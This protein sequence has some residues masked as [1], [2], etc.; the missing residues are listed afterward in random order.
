MIPQQDNVIV[1]SFLLLIDHE[2]QKQGSAYTNASGYFYPDTNELQGYYTYTCSY[3]QLCNDTSISGANVMSG[4]Y[5]NNVFTPVGSGGLVSINHYEG[6]IYF[7]Q[8]LP[9]KAVISGNFAVKDF[10]V[11]LSD[12]PDFSVV[13]E[14]KYH[15]NPKFVEA[16][17]G[18]PA[19]EHSMPAVILVPREQETKP[20]G[21]NGLDD[22]YM[23][24]RGIVVSETVFQRVA[25]SNIL[26][27]LRLK[28][29][30]IFTNLP[31][32]YMGNYTGI[33]YSYSG[34]SFNPNFFPYILSAKV[35]QVPNTEAF[36]DTTKQ[37]CMVDF[38]IST[39]NSHL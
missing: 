26:K 12:K 20:L 35:T 21:F 38:E 22:N 7:N 11:Y 23:K 19:E 29:L 3:K 2:I 14:S 36:P 27:N 13:L 28:P 30:P 37:L 39:F 4:V 31:F 25:V 9:A 32:D 17:T 8:P 34:L 16:A 5:V 15:I 6:S 18:L 24:V 33:P 10:S 1:S